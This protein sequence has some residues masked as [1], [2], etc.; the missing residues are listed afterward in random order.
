VNLSNYKIDQIIL[1]RI[2]KEN[3]FNKKKLGKKIRKGGKKKNKERMVT[4]KKK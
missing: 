1:I 2:Q 3:K 4:N